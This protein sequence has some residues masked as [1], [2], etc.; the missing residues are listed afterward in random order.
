MKIDII[1]FWKNILK[2]LIP[3][4]I[5]IILGSII[6]YFIPLTGILGVLSKGIVYAFIYIP[7]VY[8]VGMN[9]YERNEFSKLTKK[10]LFLKK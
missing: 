5:S 10:I 3:V 6:G 8:K 9:D 4:V 7:L 1:K 2:I